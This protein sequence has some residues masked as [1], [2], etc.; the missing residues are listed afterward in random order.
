MD[1]NQTELRTR[2]E[3]MEAQLATVSEQVRVL[4]QISEVQ[5]EVANE[6][7]EVLGRLLRA[8]TNR[9]EDLEERVSGRQ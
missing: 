2:L 8:T 1:L 9:V 7:T 6:S 5:V 4:R 3:A